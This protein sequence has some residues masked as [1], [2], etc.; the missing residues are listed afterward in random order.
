VDIK[1]GTSWRAEKNFFNDFPHT[2]DRLKEPLMDLSKS[3]NIPEKE[4]ELIQPDIEKKT[5]T[6]E[7]S[8]VKEIAEQP[9]DNKIFT[10]TIKNLSKTNLRWLNN[11]LPFLKDEKNENNVYK[12]DKKVLRLKDNQ[13]HLL[14]VDEPEI[15]AESFIALA[16]F[17]GI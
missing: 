8:L 12:G 1:Y 14:L 15:Y 9:S 17:L 10:Y 4:S 6:T 2:K 7:L 11:I 16:K 5:E 3:E 13:G